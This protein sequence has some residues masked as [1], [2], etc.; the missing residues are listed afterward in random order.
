VILSTAMELLAGRASSVGSA[1][2]PPPS[3]AVR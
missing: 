3:V 1:A 2:V